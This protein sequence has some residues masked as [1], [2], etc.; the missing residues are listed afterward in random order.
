MTFSSTHGIYRARD[1]VLAGVLLGLARRYDVKVFWLRVITVF[2]ALFTGF[3]LPVL[4]YVIAALVLKPEPVRPPANSDS[5][6]FYDA[7][8]TSRT[9]AIHRLKTKFDGL[10]TRIRR[11][12]DVVTSKEYDW[13]NRLANG[14]R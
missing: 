1:G 12:E 13:D 11:M 14:K 9:G 5:Q 2:F 10:D 8:T 4:A 6:E 7:Y 3:W